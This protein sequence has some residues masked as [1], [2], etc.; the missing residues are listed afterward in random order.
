VAVY[1]YVCPQCKKQFE[2]RRPISRADEVTACPDCDTQA[3]KLVSNF[4]PKVP[5]V[6]D[7]PGGEKISISNKIYD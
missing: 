5:M 7:M 2:V 4:A 3:E 6:L 1:E